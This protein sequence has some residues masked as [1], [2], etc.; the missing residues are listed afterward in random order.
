MLAVNR[1]ID[2]SV[3]EDCSD[4]FLGSGAYGKVI[5]W[6]PSVFKVGQVSKQEADNL[7]EANA[8]M[9]DETFPR[10]EVILESWGSGIIMMDRVPGRTLA[11]VAEGNYNVMDKVLYAVRKTLDCYG[12]K[13]GD[14]HGG[15]VIMNGVKVH[16]IDGSSLD[17]FSIMDPN[18]LEYWGCNDVN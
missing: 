11:K 9:G 6:G 2:H 1:E 16:V 14:L 7:N 4:C 8:R 12:I 18:F 13:H 3:I 10:A 5:A 15:N 17:F